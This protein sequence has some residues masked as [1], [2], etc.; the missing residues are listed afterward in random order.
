MSEDQCNGDD[1]TKG[2]HISNGKPEN[3]EGATNKP[4]S[5]R[6]LSTV[7][8]KLYH[9]HRW[10]MAPRAAV[11]L[12]RE[13]AG[14]VR[15]SRFE[16]KLDH[17][18]GVDVSVRKGFVRA[19]VAVLDTGS[20]DVVDEAVHTEEVCFPYVPG[21]LS[22][23]EIPPLL[24]AL[25]RLKV[26]PDLFVTDGQGRAHPRRFGLACHL[27]VLLQMPVIGVAKSRLTGVHES[28]AFERGSRTPLFDPKVEE[29][30]GEVVRTRSGVKPVYVSVGNAIDLN[31]AVEFT[32]QWATR[33][34]LPEPTRQ[35]H[36]L[37]RRWDD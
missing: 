1:G 3:R 17:V 18:A 5:L 25:K 13:L 10:D 8:V 19:S 14:L 23:R 26:V 7:N 32:L 16:G 33:Y 35:A 34:R 31:Q 15:E 28:P 29:L 21:L 9:E 30:L 27:G 4:R 12:Q 24:K 22:F 11:A 2:L 37:S 36:L 6:P 20:L